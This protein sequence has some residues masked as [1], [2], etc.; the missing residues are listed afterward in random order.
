MVSGS[1]ISAGRL[2]LQACNHGVVAQVLGALIEDAVVAAC[3]QVA[4]VR[5]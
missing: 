3:L 4:T 5:Q 2:Q 1:Y